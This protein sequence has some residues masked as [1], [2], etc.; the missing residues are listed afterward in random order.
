[1]LFICLVKGFVFSLVC[2]HCVCIMQGAILS[3][4]LGH[5][6]GDR[7]RDAVRGTAGGF[8]GM[9]FFEWLGGGVV[10]GDSHLSTRIFS[11]LMVV[12]SACHW[13]DASLAERVL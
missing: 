5:C 12:P 2:V 6:G 4:K 3:L 11:P 8:G 9:Y 7:E 1:M 10:F 13:S